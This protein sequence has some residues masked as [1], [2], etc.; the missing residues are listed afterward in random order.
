M[1]PSTMNV[2]AVTSDNG[3]AAGN[4]AAAAISRAWASP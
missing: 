3:S 4:S 1:P 2:D